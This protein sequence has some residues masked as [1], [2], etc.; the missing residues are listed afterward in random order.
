MALTTDFQEAAL[1][2]DGRELARRQTDSRGEPLKLADL[3]DLVLGSGSSSRPGWGGRLEGVALYSRLLD[4]DEIR[5]NA[6][7]Y[8]RLVESREPVPAVKL[9]ARL[10]RK[11]HVPSV[12]ELSP[13]RR[14]LAVFEHEVLEVTEGF[15]LLDTIRIAHWVILDREP[16]QVGDTP[17]GTVIELTV[18]PFAENR[19]LE[20][21]N[22]SDTLPLDF[23]LELFFSVGASD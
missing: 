8:G 10:L 6:R 4:A 22:I 17:P 19:Q 1:F 5:Q 7:A 20:N 11:S 9:S 13:Y 3:G 14:S 15:Y 23:E 16:L 2:V 18:E 12:E 21:V